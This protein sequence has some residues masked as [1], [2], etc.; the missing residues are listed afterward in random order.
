MDWCVESLPPNGLELELQILLLDEAHRVPKDIAIPH[1]SE[2]CSKHVGR[3]VSTHMKPYVDNMFQD[4]PLV[5]SSLRATLTK[6]LR[7]LVKDASGWR[8]SG[9]DRTQK[10]VTQKSVIEVDPWR[11]GA[12]SSQPRGSRRR[13][14]KGDDNPVAKLAGQASQYVNQLPGQV[15]QLGQNLGNAFKDGPGNLVKIV[16]GSMMGWGKAGK[17]PKAPV[18]GAPVMP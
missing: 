15:K 11:W 9:E 2:Y 14:R 17:A 10:S 8:C 12:G 6:K 4:Y 18:R 13:N 16:T 7:E 3:A 5:S 1:C